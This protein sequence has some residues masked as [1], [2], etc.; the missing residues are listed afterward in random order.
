[1]KKV[2]SISRQGKPSTKV[3]LSRL[4]GSYEI[5]GGAK[6]TH[7]GDVQWE[8]ITLEVKKNTGNQTRPLLYNV[9]VIHVEETN[10]FYV[11]PPNDVLTIA[12]SR[13]RGQHTEN[14]LEC[15]V[16]PLNK[17]TKSKYKVVGD[18]GEAI[19]AAFQQGETSP[20]KMLAKK[21][22]HEAAQLAEK[23]RNEV[24]ST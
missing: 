16:F 19:T 6:N 23:Q 20:K 17:T 13:C 7:K 2:E 12:A 22:L 11:V 24:L 15:F 4:T 18:L 1:M 5:V 8:K 21:L 14:A 3:V 10:T 9:L